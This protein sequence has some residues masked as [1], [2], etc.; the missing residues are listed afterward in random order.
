MQLRNTEEIKMSLCVLFCPVFVR[1][2]HHFWKVKEKSIKISELYCACG[3]KSSDPLDFTSNGSFVNRLMHIHTI[4]HDGKYYGTYGWHKQ[5]ENV[6]PIWK[7]G[8]NRKNKIWVHMVFSRKVGKINKDKPSHDKMGSHLS[9]LV[10]C[11][12]FNWNLV[13][14]TNKTWP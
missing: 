6:F 9:L 3:I 12:L 13:C 1:R 11:S 4:L 14:L 8:K 2:G 5:E 7:W 10:W